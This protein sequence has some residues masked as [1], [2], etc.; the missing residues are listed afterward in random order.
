MEMLRKAFILAE[1]KH[2]GQKYGDN[3]F[4]AHPFAVMTVLIE[5]GVMQEKYLCAALT[6]DIIEDTATHYSEVKET[7][8]KEVAELVFAL[9]DELGRNRKERKIKTMPKLKECPDALVVKLAD[10]ISNF[11]DARKNN[12]GFIQMYKKDWNE[13]KD[14]FYV[15]GSFMEPMW[16]EAETLLYGNPGR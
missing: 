13:F 14:T 8:N 7:T 16:K 9:S 10:K 4:I 2:R 12:P 11:R 6:H 5:F 1:K 3:S 15:E